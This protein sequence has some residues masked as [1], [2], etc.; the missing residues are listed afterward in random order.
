MRHELTSDSIALAVGHRVATETVPA[1]VGTVTE[2]VK[3]DGVFHGYRIGWDDGSVSI[4]SPSGRGL[5]PPTGGIEVSPR[6]RGYDLYDGRN[7]EV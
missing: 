7:L 5:T 1:R 3:G 6:V 2:L 4:W